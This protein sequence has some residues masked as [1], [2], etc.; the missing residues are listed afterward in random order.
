MLFE[1]KVDFI[2]E[3]LGNWRRLTTKK[4][5]FGII[6]ERMRRLKEKEV[7]ARVFGEWWGRVFGEEGEGERRE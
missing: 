5:N 2:K 3:A 7:K 4:R 1:N 6:V